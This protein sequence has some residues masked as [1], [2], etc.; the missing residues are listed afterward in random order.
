[1][2]K[3]FATKLMVA[4]SLAVSSVMIPTSAKAVQA[5][6]VTN[7]QAGE[8]YE[9]LVAVPG[10]MNAADAASGENVVT[11]RVAGAYYVFRSFSG[12]VNVTKT[13]GVP[14]AWINPAKNVK[15]TTPA[16]QPKPQP[17]PEDPKPNPNPNPPSGQYNQGDL[18]EVKA[19]VSG[20]MTAADAATGARSVATYGKGSY[21]IY[22]V[23]AGM[24]NISDERTEPGVW[25]NPISNGETPTPTPD[26]KPQ[27]EPTPTPQPGK[28]V[29]DKAVEIART[30]LGTPYVWGGS[31]YSHGGFDC[32]GLTYYVYGRLGISIPRTADIQW[33]VISPKIYNQSHA[34]PGDLVAF[35]YPGTDEVYHIG[36]YIGDNQF[37]HAP[38][39]GYV[40]TIQKLDWYKSTGRFKGFVRP[41]N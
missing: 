26:P 8:R 18:F 1:M 20:H 35:Q 4:L 32:S 29:G 41:W 14:G 34:K 5:T 3:N 15:G 16:P 36:I 17:K 22:R 13:Q 25:I 11:T 24:I 33:E 21:Y 38:R 12:M 28:T 9:L 37:I 19:A 10:H 6:P 27:P 39:P 23:F 30:A 7:L 31:S 40:V 2:K